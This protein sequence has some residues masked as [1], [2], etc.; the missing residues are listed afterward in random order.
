[1]Q[2]GADRLTVTDAPCAF[3]R[4]HSFLRTRETVSNLD[5]HDFTDRNTSRV[6]AQML[7]ANTWLTL[8]SPRVHHTRKRLRSSRPHCCGAVS[9]SVYVAVE[10]LVNV[11]ISLRYQVSPL[12]T[13]DKSIRHEVD[14]SVA[15]VVTNSQGPGASI[16]GVNT[17]VGG[18][19]EFPSALY[20]THPLTA[21][22]LRSVS[23]SLVLPNS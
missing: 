18:S 5:S 7:A 11:H 8:W 20:E 16:Y 2:T 4:P 13:G 1:M 12:L 15:F 23:L 6:R 21:C 9:F 3:K 22:S 17:G 14:A 19:G 10:L